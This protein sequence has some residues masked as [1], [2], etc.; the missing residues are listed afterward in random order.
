MAYAILRTAKLKSFGEIGGSLAHTFRDRETPNADVART[1]L[2]EHWGP[3]TAADVQRA[4]R[5]VLPEKRRSDA[6]LCI[7]YFIGRSP[8][9]QG[10][11][12]AYFRQAVDWLSE[13][14]GAE[15]V[16]SAHVHRDE[17]T[18]HLV[19]YVVPRDGD[20]LNAKKWLGG[21]AVLSAMQTDFWER[22]GREHG[23]ERGIEGSVAQHQTIKEYYAT[24]QKA[25]EVAQKVEF[26]TEKA[27]IDKG[28]FSTEYERDEDFARRV[29][30]EVRQQMLPAAQKGAEAVQIARREREQAREVQRLTKE[31]KAV[32]SELKTFK[33]IFE[34]LTPEQGRQL[35]GH[36]VRKGAQMRAELAAAAKE[37]A[38]VVIGWLRGGEP[39]STGYRLK[40]EEQ[41]TGRT[42]TFESPKAADD[43][44]AAGVQ[45]GDLVE[46]SKARGTV[47]RRA[48]ERGREEPG[49]ER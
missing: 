46:V 23:L 22:V 38:Q 7:E 4:I 49:R 18:P 37:A 31:L 17:T 32:R 45:L 42:V 30:R 26:P 12:A 29:A 24:V 11:D 34:G 1:P 9:W 6:V 36:M 28:L 41:S 48:Q 27:V 39:H 19:A 15:N 43:L 33:D 21:R 25:V 10:D 13:R 14:H 2:N 35:L 3:E 44:R 8:E 47:I 40:I 20:K 16:I 5:E